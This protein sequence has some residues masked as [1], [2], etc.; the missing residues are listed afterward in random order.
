MT[1]SV[2][3]AVTQHPVVTFMVI[4]LGAAF[5]WVWSHRLWTPS[6]CRSTCRCTKWSAGFSASAWAP[7]VSFSAPVGHA[8]VNRHAAGC[9]SPRVTSIGRTWRSA[10]VL[11]SKAWV[12]AS[13]FPRW[14]TAGCMHCTRYAPVASPIKWLLSVL[15]RPRVASMCRSPD[16]AG[17]VTQA[18]LP[19]NRSSTSVTRSSP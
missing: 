19:M 8:G 2:L 15:P 11:R 10:G 1:S 13:R 16:Q 17:V 3:R 4:G 6:S 18:W 12:G 5:W 14:A 9:G 7:V